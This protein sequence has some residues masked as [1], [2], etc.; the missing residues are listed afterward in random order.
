MAPSHLT[1]QLGGGKLL[2]PE[3]QALLMTVVGKPELHCA[4][5][6]ISLHMIKFHLKKHTHTTGAPQLP[7]INPL[8]S[9]VLAGK[10]L[11]NLSFSIT[12]H[13][14]L[15][16]SKPSSLPYY[17][18]MY[19]FSLIRVCR[20]AQTERSI[21]CPWTPG[22]LGSVDLERSGSVQDWYSHDS[23]I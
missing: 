5:Y 10:G 15:I 13:D 9:W 17:S 3:D 1:K 23:V 12:K 18:S 20:D 8:T 4:L 6:P 14:Y 7:N 16:G 21:Y 19:Q 2:S 11:S 22:F